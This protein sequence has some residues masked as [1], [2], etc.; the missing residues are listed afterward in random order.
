[1]NSRRI[2]TADKETLAVRKVQDVEIIPLGV[3]MSRLPPED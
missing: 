2:V 3:F 1:M